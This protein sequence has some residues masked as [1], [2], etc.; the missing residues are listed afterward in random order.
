[1]QKQPLAL[2]A[3]LLSSTT[4]YSQPAAVRYYGVIFEVTTD[5]IGKV[6]ALKFVK[7]IDASSGE[8]T[9]VDLAVPDTYITAARETLRQRTYKANEHF[10]TYTLYDPNRPARADLD[11]KAGRP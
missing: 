8:S 7:V 10:F 3:L 1:M 6:E 9:T 2:A 4:A 5:S 11:P